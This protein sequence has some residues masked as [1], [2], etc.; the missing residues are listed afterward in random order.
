[1]RKILVMTLLVLS[2]GQLLSNDSLQ[3][4]KPLYLMQSAT[5]VYPDF[6]NVIKCK[7]VIKTESGTKLRRTFHT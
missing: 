2:I 1:M 6:E 3:K 5:E 7:S 4:D